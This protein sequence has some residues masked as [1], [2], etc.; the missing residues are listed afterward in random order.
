M[1]QLRV[2]ACGPASRACTLKFKFGEPERVNACVRRDAGDAGSH[3]DTAVHIITM[4]AQQCLGL[5]TCMY[6][7]S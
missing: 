6:Y 1:H 4:Q 2:L 7:T 3:K 5:I